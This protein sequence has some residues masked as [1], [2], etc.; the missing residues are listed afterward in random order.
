MVDYQLSLPIS[1]E[2]ILQ[3]IGHRQV[4][5]APDTSALGQCLDLVSTLGCVPL[6]KGLC[7]HTVGSS[8]LQAS[9]AQCSLFSVQKQHY[10]QQPNLLKFL[11]C[12]PLPCT[13]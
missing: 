10:F 13:Q 2:N 6:S 3:H 1:T 11:C 8:Q 12:H 4:V 5:C 7:R 9:T